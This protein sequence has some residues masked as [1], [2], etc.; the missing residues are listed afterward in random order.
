MTTPILIEA[1]DL[2]G[3]ALNARRFSMLAEIAEELK[4]KVVFPVFFDLTISIRNALYKELP[5]E[6]IEALLRLDPLICA[7][8]LRLAKSK[9]RRHKLEPVSDLD[10]AF[11]LLGEAVVLR[12]ATDISATQ[13]LRSRFLA[14]FSDWLELLWEHT[15]GMAASAHVIAG[16]YTDIPPAKAMF[17][18]LCHD[19]SLYYMLYRAVQD[20]EL[21]ARPA[22]LKYLVLD[23]HGGI[24][25]ALLA[26]L[27][28]PKDIVEAASGEAS[29]VPPMPPKTLGDIVQISNTL[30]GPLSASAATPATPQAL[31]DELGVQ[32]EILAFRRTLGALYS[33]SKP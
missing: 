32:G 3:D 6:D 9:A 4:E 29:F 14:E 10:A 20:P 33:R 21:R 1:E 22:S 17:A 15:L 2:Q 19:L 26:S 16:K 11:T 8:L 28:L 12:A 25:E 5:L 18:A 31:M 23:W 27:G 24:S 13:L 7:R 30:A